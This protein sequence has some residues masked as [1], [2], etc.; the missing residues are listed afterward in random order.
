[1]SWIERLIN[2]AK[3]GEKLVVFLKACLAGVEAF[4]KELRK[5]DGSAAASDTKSE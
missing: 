3:K 2:W 5:A 1:M 4:Q